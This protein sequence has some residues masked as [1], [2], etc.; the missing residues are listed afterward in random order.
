MLE[1]NWTLEPILP[2][3]GRPGADVLPHRLGDPAVTTVRE[4]PAELR[5]LLNPTSLITLMDVLRSTGVVLHGFRAL[6]FLHQHVQIHLRADPDPE[7]KGYTSIGSGGPGNIARYSFRLNSRSTAK[8]TTE[9]WSV[10]PSATVD[11]PT[12]LDPRLNDI[13]PGVGFSLGAEVSA[14]RSVMD[15]PAA[16]TTLFLPHDDKEYFTGE[17]RITAEVVITNRPS[18]LFDKLGL[19]APGI[20]LSTAQNA[21][22]RNRASLFGHTTLLEVVEVPHPLLS[23]DRVRDT[24]PTGITA[25]VTEIPVGTPAATFA[26]AL[27]I[28]E[29]EVA[30]QR[31]IFLGFDPA[32]LEVLFQEVARRAT[33]TVPPL[34]GQRSD[35]VARLFADG[36]RSVDA[37]RNAFAFGYFTQ[38]GEFMLGEEGHRVPTVATEGG[39]FTMTRGET[40]IRI[41]LADPL[42]IG[43]VDA[44]LEGVRYAF[45]EVGAAS[46]GSHSTTFGLNAKTVETSGSLDPSLP[47]NSPDKQTQSTMLSLSATSTSGVSSAGILKTMPI[48][49]ARNTRAPFL[50]TLTDVIVDVRVDARNNGDPLGLTRGSVE[51]S[52]YLVQAAELA[53]TPETALHHGVL[54]PAGTPTPSGVFVAA[55]GAEGDHAVADDQQD[56]L[57]AAFAAPTAARTVGLHVHVTDG[58]EFVVGDQALSAERFAEQVVRQAKGA[59]DATHLVL[60][61]GGG[62]RADA[63]AVSAA[64]ALA[65]ATGLPVVASARRVHI[66]PDGSVLSG[67]L[68]TPGPHTRVPGLVPGAWTLITPANAPGV[69]ADRRTLS[70]DL[71][72]ALAE[73]GFEV[74]PPDGVRTV[75]PRVVSR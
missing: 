2:P 17:L 42:A 58:G 64:E 35:A 55:R 34:S 46:G 39:A 74:R 32:K 69:V 59:G 21:T 22:D 71:A 27:A 19:G 4:I 53:L 29:R 1:E 65:D 38:Q 41:R 28:T 8:T 13:V 10:A 33:A 37:I 45:R 70:F 62:D 18:P 63:G 47:T 75:L 7:G 3:P 6:P 25:A 23:G 43:H 40:T 67:E 66:T 49:H 15:T 11:D 68:P 57:R 9:S 16:R 44:T 26:P 36:S 30:E 51:S 48:A 12:G 56:A 54:H 73:L 60:V 14:S 50:R 5:T 72:Q 24:L 52:F 31:A 61:A 20:M